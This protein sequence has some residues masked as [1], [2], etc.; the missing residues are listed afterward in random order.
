MVQEGYVPEDHKHLRIPKLP[1]SLKPLLV[2]LYPPFL[3][4]QLPLLYSDF[5]LRAWPQDLQLV[6]S[7]K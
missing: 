4:E 2:P 5:T 3:A 1:T 7:P 6:Q